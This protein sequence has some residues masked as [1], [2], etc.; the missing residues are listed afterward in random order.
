[1]ANLLSQIDI[2]DSKKKMNTDNFIYPSLAGRYTAIGGA[3]WQLYFKQ[4]KSAIVLKMYLSG[5]KC[6]GIS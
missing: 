5:Y 3:N 1:M 6:S 2:T 4:Y